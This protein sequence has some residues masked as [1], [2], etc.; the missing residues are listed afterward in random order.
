MIV[1]AKIIKID[2]VIYGVDGKNGT[3]RLYARNPNWKS[4]G[5]D[6]NERNERRIN[7]CKRILHDG[8]RK[9]FRVR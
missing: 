8:R 1:M 6:E 9:V 2:M 7:G 4:L 3:H 5:N